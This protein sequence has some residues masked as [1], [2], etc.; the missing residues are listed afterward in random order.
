MRIQVKLY[1]T[2]R[3]AL[4]PENRGEASLDLPDGSTLKTL[5]ERLNIKRRVVIS[6]NETH[7][8]DHDCPLGDGD[9]VQIFSSIG[10]GS[11]TG[12]SYNAKWI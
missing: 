8:T 5:L 10:G 7:E 9:F 4:P 11:I 3:K 12:G 1:S 2:L 6:I